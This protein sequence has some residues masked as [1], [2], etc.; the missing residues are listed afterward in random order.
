MGIVSGEAA[1]G[2][3]FDRASRWT[4]IVESSEDAIIGATLDGTVTSWNA[5]AA[6]MFGYVASEM[7][8]RKISEIIPPGLMGDL[9]STLDQLRRGQRVSQFDTN[10]L[11]K[12]GTT[13]ELSLSISPIRDAGGVVVGSSG[14]MRDMT[15]RNRAE[16]QRR[17]L[18]EQLHQ[19]ERL[20]TLGQL[21]G[22][23][24]HDFN[25]LL[26]VIMSYAGFVADKTADR[27]AVRADVEQIQAAAE[28]ASLLTTQLLI[29]SRREQIQP[30]ALDLNAVVAGIR[31]LLATSL[32]AQIELRMDLAERLAGFVADR[33]EVGQVL[34]NL[35]VNARDAMPEGGTL[36]I[37]T[38]LAELSE[39]DA[40]LFQG[41]SPGRYVE[42]VVSDTGTG[43]S[44]DV[45]S[46]VFE[47]FFTTKPRGR[48]TGLGLSTVYGMVKRAGGC[49]AVESREGDGTTFRLDFPAIG[50]PGARG[51]EATVLVVDDDQPVLEATARTLSTNGFAVLKAG[52]CKEALALAAAHDF[53]LLLTIRHARHVGHD[54]GRARHEA[55][56]RGAGAAHVWLQRGGAERAADPRWGAGVCPEAVHR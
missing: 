16:E 42:L 39:G 56:A 40:R 17:S 50:A 44:T 6:A 5:G 34:L 30:E 21:A 26:A 51:H 48:G 28:R 14:V 1:A 35:A 22:G 53:N 13:I 15:E 8:G 43:M 10:G 24:A 37:A 25:N 31:D 12:D 33:G 38:R 7:V 3:V 52:T 27:P 23:I 46:R 55:E 18:E 32:G 49:V 36:T 19:S 41:A 47:P 2:S 54:A 11:R 4:A 29:F 9:V 20:E 45:A